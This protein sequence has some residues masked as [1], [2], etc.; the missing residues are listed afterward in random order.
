MGPVGLGTKDHFL[1]K[2]SSNLA[3]SQSHTD[4]VPD[5]SLYCFP[6]FIFPWITFDDEM[7]SRDPQTM[8]FFKKVLVSPDATLKSF[9]LINLTGLIQGTI[10]ITGYLP[11][12]TQRPVPERP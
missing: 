1:A 2:A 9:I 12:A 3:V 5:T 11:N 7:H 8:N 6:D 10:H 4:M